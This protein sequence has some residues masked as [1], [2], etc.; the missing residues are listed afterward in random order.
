[1]IL[2]TSLIINT[3]LSLDYIDSKQINYNYFKLFLNYD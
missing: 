3:F 1:M 2:K